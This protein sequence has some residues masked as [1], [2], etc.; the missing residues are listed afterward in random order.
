MANYSVE[1]VVDKE[2]LYEAIQDA[3]GTPSTLQGYVDQ[4]KGRANAMSSAY[5][6]GIWH[7]PKTRERRGDTQPDY[8]GDV[9]KK[10]RT[11]VGLVYTGNYAAKKD[12]QENNT[13]LKSL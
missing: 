1:V 9:Q 13:L 6:T 5:R 11:Q 3:E 8:K 2:K 7:D 4:I 12:N 10:G